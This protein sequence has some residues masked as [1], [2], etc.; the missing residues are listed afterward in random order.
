[1]RIRRERAED[2]PGYFGIAG[3]VGAVAQWNVLETLWTKALRDVD[4]PY[5][6][7]REFAHSVGAF[8]GWRNENQKREHVMAGVVEAVLKSEL[9]AVGSAMRI[10]DFQA[11]SGEQRSRMRAPFLGCLQDVLYGFALMNSWTK[12]RQPQSA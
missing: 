6:H 8:E 3:F 1:M 9:T 12:I 10:Q 5:L 4:V 2:Q 11:L 7:M